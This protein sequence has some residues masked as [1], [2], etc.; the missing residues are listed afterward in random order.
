LVLASLTLAGIIGATNRAEAQDVTDLQTPQRPLVLKAQGSF[1]VGGHSVDQT[2]TEVGG[3]GFFPGGHI[4]IDQM[5][6]QYMIPEE[7][8]HE[9]SVIM[10]HGGTLS[11]KSWETTPDGRMGWDEYFVR[12]GHAVYKP[13][14]VSRGRSGFN[15]AVYNDVRAGLASPAS[16]PLITRLSDEVN[17]T[18]FRFGPT[19]GVPFPD[20]QFPIAAAA[21]FSKQ[22]IPDLNADLADPNATA[23]ALSTLAMQL[24]GAVIIGH[25]ESGLYP[26]EAALVN[27]SGTKGLIDIEPGGC[28]STRW[29]NQQIATLASVPILVV[30]ADHLGDIAPGQPVGITVASLTDCQAFATRVNAAGGNV[31]V[32]HLPDVGLHG[33]SHMMMLDKNNL[34]VADLLLEWI[35]QNVRTRTDND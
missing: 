5:Y 31:Q 35:D 12:H 6:V 3:Y 7:N 28:N 33:N 27:S 16:Q 1:F 8:H 19:F 22:G 2:G 21:K 10:I 15:Q 34:Q 13:D 14:Q 24:N 11:G 26:I 17:W 20:M 9:I 23:E 30:F 18:I 29:T 25:S 4:T 32:L